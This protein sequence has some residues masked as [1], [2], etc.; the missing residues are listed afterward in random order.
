VVNDN[1]VLNTPEENLP[2][3]HF[4]EK[5]LQSFWSHFLEEIRNKDIISYNAISGFTI[6]KMEE[7]SIEIGFPSQ[8]AKEEFDKISADFLSNLQYEIQH[9][10]IKISYKS[11]AGTMKKELRTKKLIFNEL[12]EI[13]PLLKD[14]DELF[15]FD[16]N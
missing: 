11:A 7:D 3:N 13:N 8:T 14:L 5:D 15:K 10:K 16:F 6:K 1:P 4:T 2:T 12:C 9:Y